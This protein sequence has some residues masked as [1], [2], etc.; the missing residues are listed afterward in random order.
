MHPFAML[1]SL[2]SLAFWLERD[3]G[4][5]EVLLMSSQLCCIKCGAA[6]LWSLGGKEGKAEQVPRITDVL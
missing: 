6:I 2:N 3:M 5:W 4:Y 1:N